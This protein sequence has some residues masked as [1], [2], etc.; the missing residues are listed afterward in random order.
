LV[1]QFLDIV[2]RLEKLPQQTR[3]EEFIDT[4]EPIIV[5]EGR[6]FIRK[7]FER[8]EW[9]GER[10]VDRNGSDRTGNKKFK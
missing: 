9:L 4:C 6:E 10:E 7:L 3:P 5:D 1:Q 8:S 2:Q